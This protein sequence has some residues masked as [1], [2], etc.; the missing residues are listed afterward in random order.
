MTEAAAVALHAIN[1]EVK[2]GESCIVSGTGMIGIFAVKLLVISGAG[3][4]MALDTVL[5]S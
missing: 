5:R 2:T 1:Q 4:I 3:K